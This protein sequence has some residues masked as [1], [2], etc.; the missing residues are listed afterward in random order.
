MS[1]NCFFACR[2]LSIIS[3]L[4]GIL[5]LVLAS[6]AGAASRVSLGTAVFGGM[7]MSTV[8]TFILTP[9][10][11]VVLQRL[12]EKSAEKKEKNNE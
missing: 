5:P 12:R 7:L 2:A 6:G 3:F 11:F 4:L 9:V 8:L 10:L 1:S